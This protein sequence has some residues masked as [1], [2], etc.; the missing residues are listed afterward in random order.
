MNSVATLGCEEQA[1]LAT[2]RIR[3]TVNTTSA[4]AQ[5][6]SSSLLAFVKR[7]VAQQELYNG[8]ERRADLRHL[9]VMPV[10][11]LPVDENIRVAGQPQA[12]VIRDVSPPG[13]GLVHEFPFDHKRIVIQL[14]YPEDG[15]LLAC[16]VRWSRPLGPFYHIGCQ[17]IAKMDAPAE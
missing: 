14:S 6:P 3:E 5:L 9:L 17:V 16:E 15:K 2:A 10:L 8:P 4:S 1:S 13:I 7:Q 12:M 11:V